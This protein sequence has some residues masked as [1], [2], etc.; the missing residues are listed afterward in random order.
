M[1]GIYKIENLI[2]GKVYIGQS[3]HIERRWQEH[4]QPSSRSLIGKAIQKYGKEHFTFQVLD[5]CSEEYLDELEERYI[6]VYN[7][8][9]PNGYNIETAS[10]GKTSF[11][12]YD[13][14]IFTD[15]VKDITSSDLTLVAIAE[16]YDL[17]RRT[18]QRINQGDVHHDINKVYLLRDTAKPSRNTKCVDC[19]KEITPGATRCVDCANK[20]QRSVER[21]SRE[22]LKKLVRTKSFVEIGKMYGVADNSIKKWCIAEGIPSKKKDIKTYSDEEWA[23]I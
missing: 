5:E 3:I 22:V 8:V 21:P 10:K 13:Q 12:F 7:S 2:N 4:C 23:L 19:G 6:S 18:I 9:V 1:I 17:S 20:A 11:V 14:E 15:I 16:K